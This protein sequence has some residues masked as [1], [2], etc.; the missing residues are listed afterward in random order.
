MF[1]DGKEETESKRKDAQETAMTNFEQGLSSDPCNCATLLYQAMNVSLRVSKFD[2]TDGAQF[3][4]QD[5]FERIWSAIEADEDSGNQQMLKLMDIQP[6][7]SSEDDRRL[8]EYILKDAKKIFL[9]AIWMNLK[10]LQA[11][12]ELF[13]AAQFCDEDLPIEEWSGQRFMSTSENHKFVQM[14][15]SQGASSRRIWDMRSITEFQSD[16]WLFL[17]PK[18]STK[19]ETCNFDN[20][21][22][23][24]F[25]AKSTKQC[26]GA[27]GVVNKYTIHHAHFEN[28]LRPVDSPL[29]HLNAVQAN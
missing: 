21:C 2:K 9:I 23:I 13:R 14:E 29:C 5:A 12:M 3:L 25:I 18:I 17:A 15:E 24:P 28:A 1:A 7:E 27:H 10:R 22:P 4:P 11:A 26:S 8:A 16:Q 20:D 6:N 19:V